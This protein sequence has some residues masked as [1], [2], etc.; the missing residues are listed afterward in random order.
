MIDQ[1]NLSAAL[2]V[3]AFFR[4]TI[5]FLRRVLELHYTWEK[6]IPKINLLSWIFLAL[7][8]DLFRQDFLASYNGFGRFYLAYVREPEIRFIW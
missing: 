8:K 6:D 3:L 4:E 5:H 7:N 2:L 1:K